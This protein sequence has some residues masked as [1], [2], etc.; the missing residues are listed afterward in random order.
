M[1]KTLLSFLFSALALPICTCTAALA[2][3]VLTDSRIAEV[4][5]YPDS[6]M[7]SRTS[8]LKLNPGTQKIIFSNI[9]PQIDENSL[10]VGATPSESV[11]ILGAEVKKEFLKEESAEKVK[12]LQEEL[13]NLNDERKRL[14]LDRQAIAEEKQ[15][16]DSV[17]LFSQ[18]QIPKDLVTKMPAAKDL[19]DTLK[20]L[21]TRL[22]ENYTK[23]MDS[24]LATRDLQKKIEVVE[25]ELAQVSGPG[26]KLKRSIEVEIEVLK[27]ASLDLSIS[28]LVRGA[29]WQPLYD[30]RASVEKQEVELV[31]YA[32]VKQNTGEDWQEVK[33][34]L[35]TARPAI[36]GR[37][38][39]VSPW[40]IRPFQPVVM[41]DKKDNLRMK[42]MAPRMALESSLSEAEEGANL[43]QEVEKYA[44]V[45]EKGVA[46]IYQL[47]RKASVKSDGSEHK[48]P[49]SAQ[50]L[51]ADFEYSAYPRLAPY[52][53]LGS[54][55]TNAKDLQLLSGRVNIF[56]SGDFVGLSSI[57]NIGP[58][59]EFDLY[60]GV[61]EN[62]KIKREQ[63]EKKVDETLI[64]GIP[65]PTKKTTY[66][67]KLTIENYKSKKIN[68]KLFEAIPVSQDDRIKVKVTQVSLEP[69]VKDWKD[70]KGIWLWEIALEPKEKREIIYTY[71][72]EHPREMQVEGL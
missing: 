4:T 66:T 59:E 58:G 43:A 39:D 33:L 40:F 56:L 16:L 64:A 46:V 32:I 60:L 1:R 19:D 44:K 35:S 34:A 3:D 47:P 55:V 41:Y 37:M 10:K 69:K 8:S 36:G 31:S 5:V 42:A 61:D 6:A 15:F 52:A 45:E 2:Q 54:K 71:I 21:G 25:R 29:F 28:Y 11:K 20:F 26:G 12:K 22:K 48:L 9:I 57:D 50:G 17:R 23:A 70:R 49:V 62:V 72:I 18:G 30:A 51:K 13:Q 27:P 67:Y 68:T 65:S 38:P 53:Y 7:V 63:V 14:E 24:E